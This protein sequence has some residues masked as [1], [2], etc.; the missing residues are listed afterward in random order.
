MKGK[1]KR[2]KKTKQKEVTKMYKLTFSNNDMAI[3]YIDSLFNSGLRPVENIEKIQNG[4]FHI[5]GNDVYICIF[6]QK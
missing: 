5:K 6:A 1:K 3:N 4:F 2:T